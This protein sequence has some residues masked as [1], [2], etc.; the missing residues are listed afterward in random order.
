LNGSGVGVDVYDWGGQDLLVENTA[1]LSFAD[2][3]FDTIIM[4]ASINHIPN[5]EE[6]LAEANRLLKKEGRLIITNLTPFISFIWHKYAFWEESHERGFSDGELYGLSWKYLE[7]IVADAGFSI[8]RREKFSWGLN[9]IF[10]FK[11]K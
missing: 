11:K 10:Q 3:T 1:H 9:T 6:V 5:R 7:K 8:E 2:E 4:I